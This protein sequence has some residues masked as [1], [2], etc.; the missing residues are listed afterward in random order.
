MK[1]TA[2]EYIKVFYNRSRLHSTLGYTTPV[3][4]LKDWSATQQEESQ[5]A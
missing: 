3:Q 2:F 5:V 1:A 4:F